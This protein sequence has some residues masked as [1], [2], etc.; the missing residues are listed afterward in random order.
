MCESSQISKIINFWVLFEMFKLMNFFNF[1]EIVSPNERTKVINFKAVTAT[2]FET[3]ISQFVN[4]LVWLNG[5]MF[6]YEL[7]SGSESCC[8]HLYFKYGTCF[9]QGVP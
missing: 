4:K 9:E 3:A 1:T 7:S 8:S 5:T 6:I 2:G